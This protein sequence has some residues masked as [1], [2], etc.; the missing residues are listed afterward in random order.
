M[1]TSIVLCAAILATSCQPKDVRPGMWVRG[2]SVEDRV[3]DWAFTNDIEE[4]FIETRPWYGLPHSTTIWCVDLDGR[5]YVG[6][7]GD[8]K[9]VWEK[10]IARNSKA[11][12]AIAGKTYEVALTPVTDPDLAEAL[13]ILYARKYDMVEV[14]GNEVPEWR[15][16]RVS[17][18]RPRSNAARATPFDP[19]PDDP[20]RSAQPRTENLPMHIGSSFARRPLANPLGVTRNQALTRSVARCGEETWGEG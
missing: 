13:D 11:R 1:R 6:S 17:Q 4:I 2:D 16:Y 10:N 12:L 7:Y 15:Y 5:L 19:A 8:E 18:G 20:V 9:K 14:F 3:L